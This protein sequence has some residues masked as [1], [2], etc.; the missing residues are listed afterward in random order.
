M[1]AEVVP[2]KT[3]ADRFVVETPKRS[4]TALGTKFA[5]TANDA[6]TGVLVTQGKVEVSGLDQK[7]DDRPGTAARQGQDRAGPAGVGGPRLD[8]RT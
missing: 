3:E 1:F 6:G 8:A 4:V 5:V 7:A 2:A